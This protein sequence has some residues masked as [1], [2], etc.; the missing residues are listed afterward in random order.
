[1]RKLLLEGDSRRLGATSANDAMPPNAATTYIESL[2][3]GS[4]RTM[5]QAIEVVRDVLFPGV[6]M[7]D[8]PWHRVTYADSVRLRA[9][10][11]ERYAPASGN[12][13]LAAFRGV[14][15]A[16]FLQGA[17]TADELGRTSAVK[18]IRGGSAP[19]GRALDGNELA[20]LHAASADR[21]PVGAARDHALLALL[22]GAGLRR[23]ELV[24]LDLSDLD[25]E[26]AEVRVRGKGNKVRVV[27]LPA[28]AS[29]TVT[30]WVA[31]RGDE[32]G[33][34]LQPVDKANRLVRRRL[35]A[36]S[37]ADVLERLGEV[38][39]VEH[40]GAHDLRRTYASALLEQSDVATVQK[41][42]GHASPATTIRSYDRRGDACRRRAVE[43]LEGPGKAA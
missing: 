38:A 5:V 23:A 32:D 14:L 43:R 33:P 40:F 26:R 13:I 41:L 28:W 8:V 21:R 31:I 25:V 3:E 11:A 34:L 36:G 35:R 29:A 6:E 18:A 27:P 16:C 10:L 7:D 12:K 24:A 37:V 39:G 15:R 42:L 17:M 30:A 20:A 4:R 19:V 9:A 22:H 2:A 1:V